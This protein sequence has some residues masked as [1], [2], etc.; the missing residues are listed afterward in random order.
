[1]QLIKRPKLSSI[2]EGTFFGVFFSFFFFFFFCKI[3]VRSLNVDIVR[4]HIFHL[5]KLL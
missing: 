5:L 3:M 4:I 1:M 2:K